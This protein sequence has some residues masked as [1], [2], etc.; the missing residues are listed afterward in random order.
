MG[1]EKKLVEQI[2][3]MDVDVEQWNTDVVKK[4]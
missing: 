2:T 3:Y 1:S 4:A